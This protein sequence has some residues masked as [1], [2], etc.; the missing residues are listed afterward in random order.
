MTPSPLPLIAVHRDS[1][2]VS[3]SVPA[4]SQGRLGVSSV[5][6]ECRGTSLP[7]TFISIPFGFLMNV[8]YFLMY[9]CNFKKRSMN[10]ERSL[11]NG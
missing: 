10:Q 3:L 6:A 5:T 2:Q 9:K 8:Y 4:N 11:G 7:Q 1:P